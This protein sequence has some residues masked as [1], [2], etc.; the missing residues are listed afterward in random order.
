[1][2]AHLRRAYETASVDTAALLSVISQLPGAQVAIFGDC[3]LD[4]YWQ[5]DPQASEASLETGLPVRRIAG[6]RYSLGAAGNVAINARA[7]GV[8]HVELIGLIGDDLFGTQLVRL[9]AAAGIDTSGLIVDPTW[10]T[11]VY[12]KPLGATGEESRLDF[13]SGNRLDPARRQRLIG[14]LSA[15]VARCGAV[16]IN[17]QVGEVLA[18]PE[19]AAEIAALIA[20][21]PATVFVIDARTGALRPAGAWLK[22]NVHEAARLLGRPVP[23]DAA[24]VAD[25]AGA[26]SQAQ[27]APV[28][29]TRGDRGLMLCTGDTVRAFPAVSISGPT[30]P[31]GAGDTVTAL[32]V[33]AL[34]AGASPTAAAQLAGLAASVTVRQLGTTG[35]ATPADLR[36]VVIGAD[37]L[38]QPELADDPARARN[39]PGCLIEVIRD[40][41]PRRITHA[42]FDHDGT[43]STLRQGWESIMEPMMLEAILGDKRDDAELR[44]R[45]RQQVRELIDRTTGIQTLAQMQELIVVV[46]TFGC[47]PA[48]QILDC[49]GYKRIYNDALLVFIRTRRERLARHD[50]VPD[51]FIIRGVLAFLTRLQAAGV[52]IHLASGTDQADVRDE[53]AA[54]GYAHLFAG[55]HGAIGSLAHEAKRDVMDRIIHDSGADGSSLLVVGDGPVEI[56]EGHRRGALCLGIASD[57][58]R[59]WGIDLAKRTRLIRAGADLI[60]GDFLHAEHLL[61]LCGLT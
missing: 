30:D 3:C 49:H 14:K 55:I 8:G 33:S 24:G 13:G 9:A 52:Q 54:L 51:D 17:Q 20:A 29:V 27:R 31:V 5:I 7:A 35:T 57:E 21:H 36:A 2:N 38:H 43:I 37:L 19:L 28:V 45:A 12:A 16:V 15:A 34:A 60:A 26:L 6:Q 4:A 11:M 41:A 59:R 58:P 39:L 46:R 47:V 61:P 44:Q 40:V 18:D 32:L 23:A 10:E 22:V 56:R 48:A 53:A 50:L 42:I 25:M 1:M